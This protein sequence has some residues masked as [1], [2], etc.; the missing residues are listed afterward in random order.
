ML[1]GATLVWS[2]GQ[3]D[4]RR[5][6]NSA[7]VAIAQPARAEVQ[8]PRADVRPPVPEEDIGTFEG[9]S[10]LFHIR[11]FERNATMSNDQKQPEKP[12]T[13][14]TVAEKPP[15]ET[16][17]APQHEPGYEAKMKAE[18]EKAAPKP[19]E[20]EQHKPAPKSHAAKAK[21]HIRTAKPKAKVRK[22][23]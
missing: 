17:R 7:V 19:A 12:A 18:A 16:M 9:G 21:Q 1:S 3:T 13:T 14:K 15:E 2:A 10:R 6:A 22:H 23:K 20:A 11:T 4:S 5:G 8:S